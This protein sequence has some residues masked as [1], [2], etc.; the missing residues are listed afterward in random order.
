[1][2]KLEKE[3]IILGIET[4]RWDGRL[5]VI[6]RRPLVLL[7]G[8][9]N[10]EGARAL[11][12]YVREFVPTP[13]ILVYAAMRDKKIEKIA[14]ILFPLAEKVIL[15]RFPYFRAEEPDEMKDRLQGFK[16]RIVC[17][18]DARK[19]FEMAIQSAGARGSILIT[20]S[21]FLVGEIKKLKTK[22]RES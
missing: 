17:E 2:K 21:L 22:C 7:D 14:Y 6:S 12:K 18:P 10:E 9:H 19:A 13:V 4:T 3:K 11:E 20:G 16:D 1:W 15:T 8:A 5:E